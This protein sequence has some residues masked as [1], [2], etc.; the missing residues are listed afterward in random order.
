MTSCRA[1]FT[2]GVG[3]E[4]S[5]NQPEDKLLYVEGKQKYQSITG[6]MMY[7]AQASRYGIL[8]AINQLARAMSKPSKAHMEAVKHVL[9]CLAGYVVVQIIYKQDDF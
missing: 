3:S 9:R 5:L 8:Y 7:L 1:A 2:P 6:A 4:L